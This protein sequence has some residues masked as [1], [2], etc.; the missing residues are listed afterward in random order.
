MI[1]LN[2]NKQKKTDKKPNNPGIEEYRIL[3]LSN[4]I[5]AI[6]AYLF[7]IMHGIVSFTVFTM[8]CAGY[9]LFCRIIMDFF[10]KT[11]VRIP[12]TISLAGMALGTI[13]HI[14]AMPAQIFLLLG[15]G[16]FI[17]SIQAKRINRPPSGFNM[18]K[19]MILS[20]FA[21]IM[22]MQDFMGMKLMLIPY[23]LISAGIT[24]FLIQNTGFIALCLEPARH[25]AK[26]NYNPHDNP[27][28]R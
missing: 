1:G 11:Y 19:T 8:I 16:W 15:I 22:P 5:I 27:R 24:I 3:A 28:N 18:F 6:F 4:L 9:L 7:S 14:I 2:F 20:G 25:N 10:D 13:T 21:V 23:F 26:Q 12:V 17:I